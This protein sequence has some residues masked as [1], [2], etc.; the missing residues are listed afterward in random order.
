MP[1]FL[2]VE[3]QLDY[4]QKGAAEI[5]RIADL[6]E[7]LEQSRQ[8]GRPLRVKA[9]FDPTAPDLHLG[10]TVLMRKPRRPIPPRSFASWTGRRRR[11]A[12]TP[13]GWTSWAL[14]A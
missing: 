2:P 5:I 13:S 4:L 14:R 8:S 10:H 1:E 9:G 12:S 11:Y 7:R 3:E 6:R